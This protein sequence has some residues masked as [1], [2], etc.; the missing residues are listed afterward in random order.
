M[1]L[2]FGV[3]IFC[4]VVVDIVMLLRFVVLVV[5]GVLVVVVV[6]FNVDVDVIVS[7]MFC[8]V[9]GLVLI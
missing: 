5:D 9:F 2:I 1:L 4:R 8:C 6:R 3:F 7:V